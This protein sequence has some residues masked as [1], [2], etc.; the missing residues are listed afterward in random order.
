MYQSTAVQSTITANSAPTFEGLSNDG[1][2][3][4][5]EDANNLDSSELEWDPG[6]TVQADAF[7]DMLGDI[8]ETIVTDV[9]DYETVD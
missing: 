4:L 7:S 3:T 2:M 8:D 5:Q 1:F 6:E 9:S